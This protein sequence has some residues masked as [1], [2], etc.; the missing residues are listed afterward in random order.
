[1][2]SDNDDRRLRKI[3]NNIAMYFLKLH[4]EKL[5]VTSERISFAW[6]PAVGPC[7]G[8]RKTDVVGVATAVASRAKQYIDFSTKQVMPQPAQHCII[9]YAI[10]QSGLCKTYAKI[11]MVFFFFCWYFPLRASLL[12]FSNNIPTLTAPCPT[13]FGVFAYTETR[14]AR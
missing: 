14:R 8:V 10:I 7:R 1:M 12:I 13:R 3:L 4:S 6:N 11:N 2:L 5:S 9:K